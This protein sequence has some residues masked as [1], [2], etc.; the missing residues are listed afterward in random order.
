MQE[1]RREEERRDE[2]REDVSTKSLGTYSAADVTSEVFSIE[3]LPNKSSL[4][5]GHEFV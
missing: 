5:A 2:E 1:G 4:D 3:L